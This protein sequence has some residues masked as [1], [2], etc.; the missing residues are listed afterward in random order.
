MIFSLSIWNELNFYL[1][2]T[3]FES[4]SAAS[5]YFSCGSCS[6]VVKIISMHLTF[7]PTVLS[8][9]SSSAVSLLVFVCMHRD[10]WCVSISLVLSTLPVVFRWLSWVFQL[11]ISRANTDNFISSLQWLHPLAHSLTLF[12]HISLASIFETMLN[13][14]HDR[15]ICFLIILHFNGIYTWQARC[16][17]LG[18]YVWTDINIHSLLLF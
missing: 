8:E 17:L 11:I 18:W 3:G 5:K 14:S 10:C 13:N 16:S 7:L 1:Y 9:A 15:Q 4:F 12:C 6:T 2:K